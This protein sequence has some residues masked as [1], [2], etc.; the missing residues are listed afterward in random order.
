MTGASIGSISC[1][2]VCACH[3][4]WS[5]ESD[6]MTCVQTKINKGMIDV[7]GAQWQCVYISFGGSIRNPSFGN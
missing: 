7:K 1:K 6:S 3:R 5:N 4:L 2:Y